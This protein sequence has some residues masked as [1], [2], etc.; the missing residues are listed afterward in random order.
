MSPREVPV[1]KPLTIQNRNKHLCGTPQS[2]IVKKIE[3]RRVKFDTKATNQNNY[4]ENAARGESI[5]EIDYGKANL[6]MHPCTPCRN[7]FLNNK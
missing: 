3:I 1:S 2:A 5:C 4:C 6:L 7:N